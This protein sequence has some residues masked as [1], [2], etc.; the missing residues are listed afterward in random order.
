MFL[1][2]KNISCAYVILSI[3]A[4]YLDNQGMYAKTNF[5]PLD[6]FPRNPACPVRI[7]HHAQGQLPGFCVQDPGHPG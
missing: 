7:E 6:R 3:P 5:S 1:G 2:V 4:P